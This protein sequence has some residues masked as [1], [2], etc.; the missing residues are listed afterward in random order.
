VDEVW[1]EEGKAKYSQLLKRF[2]TADIDGWEH[3]IGR[4]PDPFLLAQKSSMGHPGGGSY[5]TRA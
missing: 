3:E 2:E 5:S 4:S 1:D